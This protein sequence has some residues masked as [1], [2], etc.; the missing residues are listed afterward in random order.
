ML[1]VD[2]GGLS[3]GNVLWRTF[4][5]LDGLGPCGDACHCSERSPDGAKEQEWV[6]AASFVPKMVLNALAIRSLRDQT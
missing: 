6:D 2:R 3:D 4:P 1:A 5:T